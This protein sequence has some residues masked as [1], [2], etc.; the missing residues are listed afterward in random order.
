MPLDHYERPPITEV[1]CG[2]IFEPVDGLDP[3][4]IGWFA[5]RVRD[6]FPTRAIQPALSDPGAFY[7]GGSPPIRAWLISADDEFLLQVQ[8]DRFYL[9]W[10]ARESSYPRFND[11]DGRPGIL[12]RAI[13]EFE[14]FR[15]FCAESLEASVTVVRTELAKVDHLVRGQHWT[16]TEELYRI[17]P[18][19]QS[20]GDLAGDDEATL[21]MHFTRHAGEGQ[22]VVSMT[23]SKRRER[24]LVAVESRSLG[25]LEPGED[26]QSSMRGRNEILNGFFERAIPEEVR[27]ELFGGGNT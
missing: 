19:L 12:T 22:L 6:R 2:F 4:A 10:R 1:I 7:L 26:V 17:L 18:A 9:N 24:E 5:Q 3:L 27:T 23:M 11:H 14:G 15:E 13:E 21:A 25:P 20:V 8:H 16:T